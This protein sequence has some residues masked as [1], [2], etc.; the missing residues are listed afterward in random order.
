MFIK[1]F[2]T[3]HNLFQAEDYVCPGQGM[4]RRRHQTCRNGFC[5][6]SD[7]HVSYVLCRVQ[8]AGIISIHHTNSR[9]IAFAP[10]LLVCHNASVNGLLLVSVLY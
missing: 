3:F 2:K 6:A 7:T 9:H 5:G 4:S 1:L 10:Q 8:Q